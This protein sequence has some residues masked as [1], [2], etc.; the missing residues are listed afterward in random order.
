MIGPVWET[1]KNAANTIDNNI[2]YNV[3][4]FPKNTQNGKSTRI[5]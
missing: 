5:Q 3:V 4:K 1:R 2:M